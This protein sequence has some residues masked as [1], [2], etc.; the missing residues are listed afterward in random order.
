MRAARHSLHR[1]ATRARAEIDQPRP[2]QGFEPVER[3]RGEGIRQVLEYRL[4]GRS[5]RIPAR[6]VL[7]GLQGGCLFMHDRMLASRRDRRHD[8]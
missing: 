6:P 2:G 8:G 3:A 1:G 7:V 5:V 4:V